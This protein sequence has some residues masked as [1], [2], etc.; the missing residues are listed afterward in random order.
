MPRLTNQ[1]FIEQRHCLRADYLEQGGYALTHLK[2]IDQLWLHLYFKPIGEEL[3]D[4]AVLSWRSA[5]T[6]VL[7]SLPQRAGRAYAKLAPHLGNRPAPEPFIPG[8]AY[9]NRRAADRR[10][11]TYVLVK[12]NID[13][14]ELARLVR[15]ISEHPRDEERAA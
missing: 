4:V 9:Y 2:P 6:K 5:I 1:T 7:P 14:D 13:I 12:P 8:P 11:K 3:T 10:V 15:E